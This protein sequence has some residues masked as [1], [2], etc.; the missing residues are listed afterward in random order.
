MYY[1]FLQRAPVFSL[2]HGLQLHDPIPELQLAETVPASWSKPLSTPLGSDDLHF[3]AGHPVFLL[4]EDLPNT[5]KGTHQINHFHRGM[6][7]L[8]LKTSF[9]SALPDGP[10]HSRKT[11]SKHFFS[12]RPQLIRPDVK[13][14]DDLWPIVCPQTISHCP[15]NSFSHITPKVKMLG[16]FH[17]ITETA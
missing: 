12:L 10:T 2:R 17:L 4:F 3:P 8:E 16:S 7:I 6:N 15:P 5:A 9:V 14:L 1:Y 11:N 13:L